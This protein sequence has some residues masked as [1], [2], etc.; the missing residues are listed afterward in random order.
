VWMA[1]VSCTHHGGGTSTKPS[2]AQAKWLQG[3][4]LESDHQ[5][6]HEWLYREFSDVLPIEVKG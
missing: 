1:G 4:S 2:Y 5:K 3:G 6:P